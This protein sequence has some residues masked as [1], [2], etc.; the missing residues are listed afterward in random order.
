MELNDDK[1]NKKGEASDVFEAFDFWSAQIIKRNSQ[2][3][4]SQDMLAVNTDK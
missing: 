4:F 2:R 1:K 3:I